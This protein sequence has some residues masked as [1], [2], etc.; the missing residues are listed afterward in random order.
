MYG[1]AFK[2]LGEGGREGQGAEEMQQK[3]IVQASIPRAT[4]QVSEGT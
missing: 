4:S 3:E 1:D 2:H